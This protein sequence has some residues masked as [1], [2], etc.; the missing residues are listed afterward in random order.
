MNKKWT[1]SLTIVAGL[2]T[3]V[4]QSLIGFEVIPAE[5]GASGNAMVA[6]LGE[7]L[8]NVLAFA[9]VV[10]MRRAVGP[11]TPTA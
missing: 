2:G 7:L 6:S 11:A 1:Q 9:T 3:L 4:M 8:R 10:G 5:A